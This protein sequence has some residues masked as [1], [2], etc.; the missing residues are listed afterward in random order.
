MTSSPKTI[1]GTPCGRTLIYGF[2]IIS[3]IPGAIV[4]ALI[5]H[6]EQQPAVHASLVGRWVIENVSAAVGGNPESWQL[7]NRRPPHTN[8]RVGTTTVFRCFET[9]ESRIQP[10]S[11]P[12]ASSRGQQSQE[13]GGEGTGGTAVQLVVPKLLSCFQAPA[14]GLLF[15]VPGFQCSNW[16]TATP[17]LRCD[18]PWRPSFRTRV[19]CSF[20]GS[21]IV[22]GGLV[23]RRLTRGE[24]RTQGGWD[25]C[26][27]LS[28]W[29]SFRPTAV[30]TCQ[31]PR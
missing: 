3:P 16:F 27:A 23:G 10:A 19:R 30:P 18:T 8:Y 6:H 26:D 31:P 12:A 1:F 24:E 20:R 13:P 11:T 15:P 29:C 21:Y 9:R 2:H 7:E 28:S 14:A 17:Y 25:C 4:S 5:T 22:A